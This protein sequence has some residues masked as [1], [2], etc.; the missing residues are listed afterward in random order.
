MSMINYVQ[1]HFLT[2]TQFE[3]HLGI[4]RH[5]MEKLIAAGAIPGPIYGCSGE[6]EWWSALST[7]GDELQGKIDLSHELHYAPSSVWWAR[8]ALLYARRDGLG[9]VAAAEHCRAHFVAGFINHAEQYAISRHAFADC[10]VRGNFDIE[11]ARIRGAKEWESWIDGGYAV[12]LRRFSAEN[13]VRKEAIASFLRPLLNDSPEETSPPL[14]DTQLFDW[15]E[16]LESLLLPFA[17]WERTG[18]TPGRIIDPALARLCLGR[19]WPYG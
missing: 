6:D 9:L 13:C 3:Q 1:R 12:C 18:G 17:P 5:E 8:R 7:S 19:E 2:G 15:V 16:E 14:T 4:D 10:Y 11:A